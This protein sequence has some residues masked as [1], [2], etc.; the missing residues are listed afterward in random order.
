MIATVR[1][2]PRDPFI[3]GTIISASL[4]ALAIKSITGHRLGFG[5]VFLCTIILITKHR[6][7]KHGILAAIYFAL[8]Y[9]YMLV[10]PLYQFS[11]PTAN[12]LILYSCGFAA[13]FLAGQNMKQGVV[14]RRNYQAS[15]APEKE[16]AFEAE[17]ERGRQRAMSL[18]RDAAWG[19]Q[20]SL[21]SWEMRQ[22]IERG[23]WSGYE[24]GFAHAMSQLLANHHADD[25]AGDAHVSRVQVGGD[26]G[27]MPV[28]HEQAGNK[29]LPQG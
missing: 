16:E 5:A 24:A 13:A 14:A 12:E 15:D 23:K 29:V 21:I 4:L 8:F 1:N 11:V 25:G 27:A 9:N 22:M 6:S 18:I 7:H 10:P 2:C 26:V 3:V 19:K 20:P 28:G 17:C